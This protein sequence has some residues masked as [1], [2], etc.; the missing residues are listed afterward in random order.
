MTNIKLVGNSLIATTLDKINQGELGKQFVLIIPKHLYNVEF[1]PENVELKIK[2]INGGNVLKELQSILML[3]EDGN[4]LYKNEFYRYQIVT[5]AEFTTYAGDIRLF[6][7]AKQEDVFIINSDEIVLTI[8]PIEQ[9]FVI[10][11]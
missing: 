1:D 5:D 7:Q 3:D 2:Y 9:A 4:A 10:E 8:H 11:N 6:V